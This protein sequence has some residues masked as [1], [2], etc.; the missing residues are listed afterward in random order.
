MLDGKRTE[1]LPMPTQLRVSPELAEDIRFLSRA[2]NRTISLQILDWI[3]DGI[4]ANKAKLGHMASRPVTSAEPS[5]V[6]R[7]HISSEE[8]V[9]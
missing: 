1:R 6:T 3:I 8:N 4:K 5:R 9:A 2:N 7:R